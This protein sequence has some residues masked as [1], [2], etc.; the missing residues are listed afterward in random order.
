MNK[1]KAINTV[2]PVAGGWAGAAMS[3][4]GAVMICAGAL[5]SMKYIYLNFTTFKQLKIAK[6]AKCHRTNWQTDRLTNQPT[7]QQCWS[8]TVTYRLLCPCQKTSGMVQN[9]HKKLESYHIQ[10][11][12]LFVDIG[13]IIHFFIAFRIIFC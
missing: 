11:F 4:A 6:K 7:D 8:N 1:N 13:T 12:G 10:A 9:K 3:G 5:T 2:T